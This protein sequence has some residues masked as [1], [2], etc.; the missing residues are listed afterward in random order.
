MEGVEMIVI[1]S[2]RHTGKTANLINESAATGCVIVTI[3]ER[4]SV[5][6]KQLAKQMGKKIPE[7]ITHLDLL[8]GN[9]RGSELRI[10]GLL[11][12]DT[13]VFLRRF[14]SIPIKTIVVNTEN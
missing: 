12:D 10:P 14:T 9:N 6:L 1:A 5:Y 2:G 11:M 4:T 3:D 8:M 13:D 7:P